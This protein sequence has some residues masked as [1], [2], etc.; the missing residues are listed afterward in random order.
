MTVRVNLTSASPI[1]VVVT[2]EVRVVWPDL[3]LEI[4]RF[5]PIVVATQVTRGFQL[6]AGLIILVF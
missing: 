6:G 4:F 5:D 2:R 3:E 1:V